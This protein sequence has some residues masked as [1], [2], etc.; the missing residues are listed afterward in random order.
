MQHVSN[1]QAGGRRE[2]RRHLWPPHPSLMPHVAITCDIA[3]VLQTHIANLTNSGLDLHSACSFGR[4]RSSR[5]LTFS[6]EKQSKCSNKG[7]T[8]TLENKLVRLLGPLGVG[9]ALPVLHWC[10]GSGKVIKCTRQAVTS[11]NSPC[12][13][14]CST[15]LLRSSTS[16]AFNSAEN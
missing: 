13:D 7:R 1:C 10:K 5:Q 6:I 3:D 11:A 12:Q 15:G 9:F 2:P 14:R 8:G 16:V 4:W